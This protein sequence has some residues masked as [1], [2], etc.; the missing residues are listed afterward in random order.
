MKSKVFSLKQNESARE[1]FKIFYKFENFQI[2]Q[3]QHRV[4][5]ER[6]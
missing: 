5:N 3:L 6:R 2:A 1:R 4:E